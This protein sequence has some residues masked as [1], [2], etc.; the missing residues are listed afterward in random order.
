MSNDV[1]A[2]LDEV[3]QF[4]D[5]PTA[6]AKPA[7]PVDRK[8]IYE[9]IAENQGFFENL[10]AGAGGAVQGWKLG[11]SQLFGRPVSESEVKE[12]QNAVA[13][14]RGTVG[15]TVGEI[16][17]NLAPG[18]GLTRAV[19]APAAVAG[20]LA[21]GGIPAAVAGVGTGVAT[22]MLE[23]AA[24]PVTEDQSRAQNVGMTGLFG[25]I[26]AAAGNL[27]TKGGQIVKDAVMPYISPKAAQAAAGKAL[28][29]VSA[30]KSGDVIRALRASQPVVSP[31]T[32]GQA[33]V[34]QGVQA[35]EVVALEAV[36]RKLFP[37]GAEGVEAAQKEARKRAIQSFAGD[38]K[39]LKQ[40]ITTRET[41]ASVNYAKALNQSIKGDSELGGILRDPYVKD[42]L[43]DIVKLVQ[44]KQAAGETVTLAQQ[45]QMIK[46]E[47]DKTLAGTP[48]GKPSSNQVRA[49]TDV[50]S[51]LNNWLK[52][53]VPG[54][55][56]AG[57][58]Y[59]KDSAE[60]L[61]MRVGQRLDEIL[62]PNLGSKERGA[63]F[64]K[65][66][67]EET[68]LLKK[69]GGFTRSDLEVQMKPENMAKIR[70]VID[71]LE[72]NTEF[73][74]QA[75]KGA[76]G[77]NLQKVMGKDFSVP[78]LMNQAVALARDA[79]NRAVG[80]AKIKTLG[81]LAKIMQDPQLTA[82]IMETATTKEKNALR[83]LMRA[84]QA[85]GI[86]GSALTEAQQQ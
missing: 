62:Q 59:A 27:L 34:Q 7:A 76:S 23:G 47:L 40:A 20:M 37:A 74:D 41:T 42:T 4:L 8:K 36:T 64:A 16:V 30:D 13:G 3:D 39:A 72:I 43:P 69:S 25:G 15:G 78:N 67:E 71:E 57:E 21:K 53:K 5:A 55:R 65:A 11:L 84:T 1:D 2:F 12:Y 10:A 35:P 50:Q 28:L 45:L 9:D 86:F 68:S 70:N 48:T 19:T 63:M 66:V 29:D 77:A 22:G 49:V 24:I 6:T 26:G 81:E 31:Q 51:R 18:V 61:Q 44:A 54:Y 14:L 32:A 82:D 17:A 56:E 58:Q 38:E 52:A 80:K 33:I 73:A 75:R 85:G 83:F 79:T 46:K 60:I